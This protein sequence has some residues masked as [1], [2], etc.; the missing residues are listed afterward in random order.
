MRKKK[1]EKPSEDLL[2]LTG[3]ETKKEKLVIEERLETGAILVNRPSYA[4]ML[5]LHAEAQ[6]S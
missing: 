1:I 6:A 5:K 3:L 2:S 4:Q